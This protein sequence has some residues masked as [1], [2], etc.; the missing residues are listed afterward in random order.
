MKIFDNFIAQKYYLE[1]KESLSQE[2][3]DALKEH[4]DYF[5]DKKLHSSLEKDT[6]YVTKKDIDDLLEE[7]NSCDLCYGLGKIYE[8]SELIKCPCKSEF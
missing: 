6:Y 4:L 2:K 3:Q 7:V 8:E 5:A 1:L